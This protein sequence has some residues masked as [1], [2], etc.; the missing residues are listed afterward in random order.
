MKQSPQYSIVVCFHNEEECVTA[1][2]ACVK[3]AMEQLGRSFE[4]VLVDDGSNDS[5]YKLLE[6][7]AAVDSRV[8]A[9]KLRRSFGQT[10]ALAAGME[11]VSGEFV[12][13]MDCSLCREPD[14]IALFVEKLEDGYDV[15]CG[16]RQAPSA[17]FS[18]RR[19]RARCGGWLMAR[20]SGIAIHDFGA[21]FKGYRHEV[22]QS[23]PF[24]GAMYRFIPVVANWYGASLCEV[25]LGGSESGGGK[26]SR[27]AESALKLFFD[28]ISIRFL[29][30]HFRQPLRFFG[31]IG[32]ASAL[33][34]GLGLVAL[35]AGRILAPQTNLVFGYGSLLVVAAL[36]LVAGFLTV[37]LGLIG[38]LLARHHYA[39]QQPV[40]Y[41]I[42]KVVR[43]RAIHAPKSVLSDFDEED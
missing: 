9:V 37:V 14:E 36:L 23:I 26:N 35:L 34:G 38:D 25:Q 16:W 33:V 17:R 29:L 21:T 15:V 24:Y 5:S 40:S 43:L 31:P 1:L 4:L 19:L 6:E 42:E 27:D 3:Q 22:L 12:L 30:K 18:L 2:Y 39:E 41:A 8:L 20:L 32:V 7:I 10:A 13:A 11:S 28:L